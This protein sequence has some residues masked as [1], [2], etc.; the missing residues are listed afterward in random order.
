MPT[1]NKPCP[2]G[3]FFMPLTGD[4]IPDCRVAGWVNDYAN[5]VCV[6]PGSNGGQGTQ[7]GGSSPTM[8]TTTITNTAQ[9]GSQPW[10]DFAYIDRFGQIDSE[11]NYYQ[12][13]INVQIPG[14]YPVVAVL[15]GTV[16]SVQRTGWG[17]TVVTIAL[18]SPLN[19][20]A[21]HSFYEHMS[22]ATVSVG[23]HVSFGDLVGYNNPSGMVPLGFGL[24]SGDVYGS[25]PAW[26]TLQSDLAPGG[27]ML[28][29]PTRYISQLGGSGKTGGYAVTQPAGGSSCPAWLVNA[30]NMLSPSLGAS[31]C[32]IGSQGGQLQGFFDWISNPVRILKMIAGIMCIG[33]AIVLLVSPD[34]Q[35][36]VKKVPFIP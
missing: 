14:D 19:P 11:G 4:C 32:S 30:L 35:Q 27:A 20:V 5:G 24:Y 13:D 23:Q 36:V 7:Q 33:L 6:W 26:Q 16:S 25:G 3:M 29:D 1:G 21:T 28:L 10:W 9:S 17:Q 34:A 22:Y 12:P 2:N 31:V 15:P 8:P 18:D